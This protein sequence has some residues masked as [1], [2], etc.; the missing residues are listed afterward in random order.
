M[1]RILVTGHNGYIGTVMTPMLLAAGH[2]VV[3]LDTDYYRRCTFLAGSA[4][5]K[6]IEKD[7]RDIVVADLD[8]FDAVV[9][10]AALSNDPLGDLNAD[11][12]YEINY[13][14]S[15]RLARLAREA[16]VRRY[17]FA[18]SCSLYGAAGDD[19]LT[20]ESPFNPVTPYGHSKV[21]SEQEISLLATDDFSPTFLR[22]A[23]A[24]GVS[25][26]HR[27]DL[28]LNNLVAWAV[29]T[30]RVFIKSD[31][32]PWRP[33]VHIEDISAAFLAVL[34]APQAVVHNEAFNVGI[35]S[36]NYRIRELA[37]IVQQL[38]PDCVVEYAAD[39]SPDKRNYRVDFTKIAQK[40]PQFQANW[41]AKKGVEQLYTT[42][43]DKD[44]RVEEFEGV[45]YRR[46]DHIK[47][48]M[49]QGLL[50]AS[51]RWRQAEMVV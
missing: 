21:L 5:V 38:V 20:E 17:L 23:T 26:R 41:T 51:L 37:T 11:L 36:E 27:F 33:I 12:T 2:E 50:D 14:S 13:R 9:H 43:R 15:V 30:G 3:G 18:S 42:Y 31:G 40:L 22:N 34:A 16:G 4:P 8:G 49:N 7:I 39:A 1:S 44:L 28:V 25:P 48:L 10:L 47:L 45:K 46:V 29:A 24:Y 6:T 32:T 19:M 35:N